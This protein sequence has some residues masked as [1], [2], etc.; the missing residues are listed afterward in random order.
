MDGAHCIGVFLKSV[1]LPEPRFSITSDGLLFQPELSLMYTVMLKISK[2]THMHDAKVAKSHFG[3]FSIATLC[4][5]L[6]PV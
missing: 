1:L 5:L 2:R 4:D 3:K 6:G